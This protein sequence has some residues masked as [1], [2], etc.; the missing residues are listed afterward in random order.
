MNPCNVPRCANPA[1]GMTP[2]RREPRCLTHA[3]AHAEAELDRAQDRV[4]ALR[5]LPPPSEIEGQGQL[6]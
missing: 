3:I 2:A 5:L 4:D 1:V 6:L